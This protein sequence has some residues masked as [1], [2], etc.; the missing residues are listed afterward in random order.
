M[1]CLRRSKSHYGGIRSTLTLTT[2]IY[3]E[4]RF[5]V[6]LENS[7]LAIANGERRAFL[8]EVVGQAVDATFRKLRTHRELQLE[9]SREQTN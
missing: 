8:H 7:L 6:Q 3:L 9:L 1:L 2:R 4:A 5:Y